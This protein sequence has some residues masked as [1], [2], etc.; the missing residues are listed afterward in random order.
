MNT[1]IDNKSNIL[2][3]SYQTLRTMGI[4]K[5]YADFAELLGVSR[6]SLSA[7]KGGNEKYLTNSLISKIEYFM[8]K[9]DQQHTPEDTAAVTVARDLV[10]V[11]PYKL[12]QEKDCDVYDYIYNEKNNVQMTPRVLQFA[13]TD[14]YYF[15]NT[16][17]MHPQ[18]HPSDVL[19]LTV[20]PSDAPVING[21]VYVISTRTLGLVLRYVYDRGNYLELKADNERF[22]VFRIDKAQ[23]YTMFRVIG[24]MRTN[25]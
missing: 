1:T 8:R 7:A 21:E 13:K 18:F 10:P 5:T 2:T 11:I 14:A 20:C 15:V 6:S 22:E 25:I 19:A 3:E 17:A 24:L 9:Y 23:V 4:I 12:Y 16:Y